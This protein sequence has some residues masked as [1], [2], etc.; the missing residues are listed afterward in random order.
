MN[1]TADF[2]IGLR[3]GAAIGAVFG[4][5]IWLPLVIWLRKQ[6][7]KSSEDK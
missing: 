6:C 4:T 1:W 3:V 2:I 5:A 7:N